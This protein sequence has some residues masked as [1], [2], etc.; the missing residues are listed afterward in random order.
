MFFRQLIAFATVAKHLN[1]SKAAQ[2][3]RTSQPSLSRHIKLL[4]ESYKTQLFARHSKGMELT[5]EGTEFLTHINPLMKQLEKINERFVK[6]AAAKTS[7]VLRIGGTYGPSSGILPSLVADFKKTHPNV[8][9]TLRSH[10]ASV[11][12][13]MLVQGSLELAVISTKPQSD[14]FLAEIFLPQKLVAFV[15]AADPLAK[16]GRLTLADL[17]ELPLVVREDKS[18]RGTT[19]TLLRE[20]RNQ[21][22]HPNISLSCESPESVKSAVKKRLGVGFLY[23]DTIKDEIARG[24]FKQLQVPD[25]PLTGQTHI[26]YHKAR[27]LSLNG[28]AFLQL[29]RASRARNLAHQRKRSSTLN[30][31]CILPVVSSFLDVLEECTCLIA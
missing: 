27:P 4:E 2:E 12:D 28:E 11:I 15:A 9:V 21:D 22:R 8:R 19:A 18:G 6:A 14:E 13:K 3:L 5:E 20:L 30:L 17:E 1:T 23:Y 10:S 16:K 26:V 31:A 29:L 7:G 25:L 24:W